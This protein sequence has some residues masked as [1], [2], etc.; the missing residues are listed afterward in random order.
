MTRRDYAEHHLLEKYGMT[1]AEYDVLL[2]RQGGVCAICGGIDESKRL[3]IDHCHKT[4]DIRGLLC[5]GCN[6]GLGYFKDDPKR[7]LQAFRYIKD[8]IEGL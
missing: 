7:L 4:N 2:R 5:N 3:G 8:R 6:L 1:R